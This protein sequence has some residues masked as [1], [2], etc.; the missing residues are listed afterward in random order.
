MFEGLW[1]CGHLQLHEHLWLQDHLWLLDHPWETC[2]P[3]HL[4]WSSRGAWLWAPSSVCLLPLPPYMTLVQYVYTEHG[5]Q[6]GTLVGVRPWGAGKVSLL[7]WLDMFSPTPEVLLHRLQDGLA[8][9]SAVAP[10]QG[11]SPSNLS[12]D[13]SHCRCFWYLLRAS[14]GDEIHAGNVYLQIPFRGELPPSPAD[15]PIMF[16]LAKCSSVVEHP[17]EGEGSVD[18]VPPTFDTHQ[19][20]YRHS[21]SLTDIPSLAPNLLAAVVSLPGVCSIGQ[22]VHSN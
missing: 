2:Q 17:V 11:L 14:W 9:P 10:S 6:A 4:I 12:A 1:L 3:N 8:D 20:K 19:G 21:A 13:T 22:I 16:L 15:G 18:F 5:S 7:W